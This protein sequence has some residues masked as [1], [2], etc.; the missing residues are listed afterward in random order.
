MHNMQHFAHKFRAG[1]KDMLSMRMFGRGEATTG[2]K[3]HPLGDALQQAPNADVPA[4][5]SAPDAPAPVPVP[6]PAA[7]RSEDDHV[8][9]FV[10]LDFQ[11]CTSLLLLLFSLALV[12][13][14]RLGIARSPMCSLVA[15]KLRV[16]CCHF[17]CARQPPPLPLR[18][19]AFGIETQP[20]SLL[21]C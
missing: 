4:P 19:L 17:Y 5:L 10:T 15:A 7:P 6:A 21:L 14:Q 1:L 3:Q 16:R 2:D 13:L 8:K 11:E 18:C 9:T 20:H 12:L